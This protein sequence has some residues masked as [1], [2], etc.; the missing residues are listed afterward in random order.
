MAA[1]ATGGAET[2]RRIADPER[3]LTEGRSEADRLR[4]ESEKARQALE[5]LAE[6]ERVPARVPDLERELA[7]TI[8]ERNAAIMEL[9]QRASG[10]EDE[11][12]D[13]VEHHETEVAR[14]REQV[15][16]MGLMESTRAWRAGVRYWSLRDRI[17]S[18]FRRSR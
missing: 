4:V 7:D 18:S 12:R 1:D 6:A 16:L 9:E 2:D 8:R 10:R 15:R 17:E 3:A 11:L 5:R 13:L 14:L